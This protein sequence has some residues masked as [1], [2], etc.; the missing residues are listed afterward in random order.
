MEEA[1]KKYDLVYGIYRDH[2]N[3]L[4]EFSVM[5]W[6]KLDATT[7]IASAELFEK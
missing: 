3:Q 7:L 1:N 2:I 4:K 6:N 5:S